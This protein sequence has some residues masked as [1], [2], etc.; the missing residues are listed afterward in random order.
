[1]GL[2]G[3]CVIAIVVGFDGII[4]MYNYLMSSQGLYGAFFIWFNIKW[5]KLRRRFFSKFPF[6]V[7][8]VGWFLTLIMLASL[9]MYSS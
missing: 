6:P 2:S 8:E 7:I 1:M 3:S 9:M 4:L 5:A